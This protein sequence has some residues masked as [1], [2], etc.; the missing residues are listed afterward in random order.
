[1]K[2][3]KYW[4]K[5]NAKAQSKLTTK[6]IKETQKQMVKYYDSAMKKVILQFEK[7]YDKLVAN[8][9]NGNQPTPADLYKLDKYWQM[10]GQLRNELQKLGDK[11]AE[12]LSEM[13]MKQF[14]D[15]YRIA[16]LK[17]GDQYNKIDNQVINQIIKSVWCADGKTWSDRVWHNTD[18]LYDDLNSHLTDCLISGKSTKDLTNVLQADFG[19]S[20]SRAN[21]LVTTEMAHIQTEAAKERYKDYGIE[22]VEILADEDERRCDVCGKLHKKRYKINEKLPIPAHPRCRCCI[23]PVVEDKAELFLSKET[24]STLKNL[25]NHKNKDKIVVP[26]ENN[27]SKEWRTA[28]FRD[29]KA[30]E[31]HYKHLVEYGNISFEKYVE[32]ARKLLSQ[33]IGENID[34]FINNSGATYRYDIINNDFAIGKDGIIFTRFKPKEFIKYWERIK[35]NELRQ[36]R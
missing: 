12:L 3:D 34:G 10:Q 23:I 2:I 4:A 8:C 1:M 22:E 20:Y 36:K 32:G 18:L 31:E 24:D 33:P 26:R 5:R 28:Q 6:S 13:F 30:E 14:K 11:Q 7:T 21:S 17:D 27:I 9:K 16:A 19:V 35:K 15:I 25:T 29:K